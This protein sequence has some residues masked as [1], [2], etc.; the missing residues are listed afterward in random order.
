MWELT[1]SVCFPASISC[2]V[3][4]WASTS[5]FT[6]VCV[7]TEFLPPQF[8]PQ[9]LKS[10]FYTFVHDFMTPLYIRPYHD[11]IKLMSWWDNSYVQNKVQIS[12]MRLLLS[13]LLRLKL[14]KLTSSAVWWIFQPFFRY[15]CNDTTDSLFRSLTACAPMR[16]ANTV[17][18]SWWSTVGCDQKFCTRRSLVSPAV[19]FDQIRT[20]DITPSAENDQC[21]FTML[22]TKALIP[23]RY[24]PSWSLLPG[25]IISSF[26]QLRYQPKRYHTSYVPLLQ[27]RK[28]DGDLMMYHESYRLHP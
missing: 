17:T 2:D 15:G 13:N 8:Q 14:T 26:F 7:F 24:L 27:R 10:D 25:M 4:N 19:V 3:F 22:I 28:Y 21:F 9:D 5:S 23:L 18:R 11:C 16:D 20:A 12:F 1:E 6:A